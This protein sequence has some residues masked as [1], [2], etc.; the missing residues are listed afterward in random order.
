MVDNLK[1][2]AGTANRQLGERVAAY[3]HL[4]LGKA[5]IDRFSDG[6]IRVEI[7]ENVRG[8]EVMIIQP[9]CKPTNGNLME[10]ILLAD[11]LRRS[12]VK[13]ITAV[14]P[15]Y[16]YSRQ[17][18]RPGYSR[19]P[20]SARVIADLM[21]SVGVNH[22]VTIDIH[23]AQIQGFFHIPTDNISATQLFV[24]DIY[25]KWMDEN[26]II[27]SPDVGG[28][29]RARSV[30]K[31]LDNMDLAI[32][33]KRRPKANVSEVMNIIGDIEDRTCI[34][35][36]DMV[37][38]AGTM[39]KAADALVER[40]ARRVVCYATHGVLSGNAAENIAA[41]KLSELIVTDTIP[42]DQSRFEKYSDVLGMKT[43]TSKV[44]QLSVANTLAETLLRIHTGHSISEILE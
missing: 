1:I 32:V 9:T 28:V 4:P 15:Y 23:A 18:R 21:E 22:L 38:T 14:V 31:H 29:S 13:S 41:S 5:D 11:A 43:R 40:G 24:G 33:D 39:C 3:L 19:V 42:L 7:K 16:G 2:F 10:L 25:S 12:S 30:A 8:A 6:E 37:D 35:I 27:V 26:P 44:R 17:D 20:I 34:M 36:D